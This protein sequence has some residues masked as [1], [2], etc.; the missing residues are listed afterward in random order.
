M[1]L[2]PTAASKQAA[3]AASK[4]ES[5]LGPNLVSQE[6]FLGRSAPFRRSWGSIPQYGWGTHPQISGGVWAA[7]P[8][9]TAHCW[10]IEVLK[11]VQNRVWLPFLSPI[12]R[13]WALYCTKGP[14][15]T[16]IRRQ[17]SAFCILGHIGC[18]SAPLRRSWESI[19]QLRGTHCVL[20][21]NVL[22]GF[23]LVA[24]YHLLCLSDCG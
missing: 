17:S 23:K 1:A 3:A 10:S 7:R 21:Q 22:P 18:H 12:W 20:A 24:G 4:Q 2:H 14:S 9:C 8:S 16:P 5:S 15:G 11:M 13:K 6:G 19:P